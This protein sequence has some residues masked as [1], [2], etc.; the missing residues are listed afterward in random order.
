MRENEILAIYGTN[1]K[2][3]TKQLLEEPICG[4]RFP[5]GSVV[6]ESSPIW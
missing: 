1:Y 6:L 5:I 3:M 2:E 4:G